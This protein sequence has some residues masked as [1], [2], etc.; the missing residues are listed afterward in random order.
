MCLHNGFA[1][2]RHVTEGNP[3]SHSRRCSLLNAM[4]TS[5]TME[6]DRY[7]SDSMSHNSRHTFDSPSRLFPA[8]ILVVF[9]STLSS[10]PSPP[11]ALLP[12]KSS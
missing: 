10:S 5:V 3:K 12:L 1:L 11:K 4:T 8:R 6:T 9:I 7:Y 2:L